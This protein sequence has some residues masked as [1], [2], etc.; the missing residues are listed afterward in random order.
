MPGEFPTASHR[1]CETTSHT[2]G[3]ACLPVQVRQVGGWYAAQDEMYDREWRDEHKGRKYKK[4]KKLKPWKAISKW[5]LAPKL[6][7]KIKLWHSSAHMYLLFNIVLLLCTKFSFWY[8]TIPLKTSFLMSNRI[9]LKKN[10]K[11]IRKLTINCLEK[12]V[13]RRFS[14]HN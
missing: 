1:K 5:V 12:F 4:K 10:C 3:G 9:G 14:T 11:L 6:F 7:F 8:W 13:C 2:W